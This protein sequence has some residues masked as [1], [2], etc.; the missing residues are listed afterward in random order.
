MP[1]GHNEVSHRLLVS[2]PLR[3]DAPNEAHND[4]R[5]EP[6]SQRHVAH[7]PPDGSTA[8]VGVV[9]GEGKAF[10][11]PGLACADSGNRQTV[12]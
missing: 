7:D 2:L 1:V 9:A 11:A 5:S 12:C 6:C 3:G 8:H 10:F 4:V